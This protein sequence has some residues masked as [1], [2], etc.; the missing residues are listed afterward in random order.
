MAPI[1]VEFGPCRCTPGD[2]GTITIVYDDDPLGGSDPPIAT[3][4][5]CSTPSEALLVQSGF[6]TR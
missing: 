5:K 2:P 1:T 6:Q 3:C 4:D